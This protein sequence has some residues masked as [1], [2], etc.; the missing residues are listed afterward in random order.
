MIPRITDEIIDAIIQNERRHLCRP[1]AG[2]P[3]PRHPQA[4]GDRSLLKPDWGQLPPDAAE[5]PAATD[6]RLHTCCCA[7]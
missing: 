5:D 1:P 7:R 3:Y 2:L 4:L 6:L